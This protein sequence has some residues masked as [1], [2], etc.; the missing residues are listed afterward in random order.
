MSI[1][2]T[3][4]TLEQRGGPFAGADIAEVAGLR[5][6][7]GSPRPVFDQDVWDLSGLADAP[8]IMGAHRK[9]L[10]FTQI[11]NPR[12]RLVGRQ[13]LLARMAPSHP[14]V[15]TLP[16]AIRS[17]LNPNSL[18]IV[19]KHL[20]VWFNHLTDAGVASL[21][22][23]TQAHCDIYLQATS[24][25]ADEPGKRLSPATLTISVRAP[26]MLT[27]YA[28]ILS[29]QYRTGFR[30]W[31]GRSPDVVA[32]Y[33]RPYGNRVPP[34]PDAL[35]RPLLANT[36]YLVSTIAPLLAVESAA[37]RAADQRESASRRGL[38]TAEIPA[39][40]E[41]IEHRAGLGIPAP[42][43]SASGLAQRLAGG[44][45]P[46]DPLLH[47]AWHPVV[48]EA[49]GAMGHRRDLE[50]LRPELEQWVRRCGIEQPWCR[51]AALVAR[52]DTGQPITW[53]PPMSRPHLDTT[54]YA[55]TSACFF[56][57]SALSGMRASELLELSAG[58]RR[59]D[60]LPGGSPRFRLVTR[61]TKGEPF[62][63]VQDAWVV[64]AD[65]D[66]AIAM[67]EQLTGAAPGQRLFATGSNNSRGR[68]LA[69]RQWINGEPGRR[70]GLAPIPDGAINPRALRRTLALTIAQRPHGLMAA[71]V[72]LKHVSIATTEGYAARPG[73]QQAAFIAEVSAEE[74]AEHLRLTA[75]AY[76][77]YQRGVLPTGTGARDLIAAFR[78]VDQ[79][80]ARH[81]P[82]PVT[83][84]DDRRV[85]RLLK[86]TAHS[87]HVGV[88][89]YCWFTDPSKALC[90]KLAG[91]PEADQPLIG[92]C[93]SAR[94]PQATHHAAHRPV[95]AEHAQNINSVFLGNPRL[96]KPEQARAQAAF[97]RAQRVL[98]QIDAANT[99][100]DNDRANTGQDLDRGQ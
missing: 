96:S 64:I 3:A 31:G 33:E 68:F 88:G 39:L 43:L 59:R 75:A 51:S 70:L 66:R 55:L 30:P 27:L 60:E 97:D 67:A 92:M 50:R 54:V 10:D 1:L 7:P 82:G 98:T 14:A 21:A 44:W 15:A 56:L 11:A 9:I 47:M 20:S 4:A 69:L 42:C 52:Q 35:V 2:S 5:L 94:C 65:V 72:H 45:N 28:E 79:L 12:W 58:C 87:L 24:H 48:L 78:S 29:D 41:A 53:T 26:Q 38:L 83:V 62:G 89:N 25:S 99:D 34:V 61:R 8:V 13:Y 36:L 18:W 71:K 81:D 40:R 85:E 22:E 90:L 19:L 95:W 91:T 86:A 32:G 17:P 74:E 16:H 80:L 84:I 46:H 76:R 73:G 77:D 63:G 57:T 37:A 49:A 6:V 23:V 93:D 100:P